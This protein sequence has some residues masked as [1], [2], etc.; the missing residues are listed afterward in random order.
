M[1]AERRKRECIGPPLGSAPWRHR[2]TSLGSTPRASE[3]AFHV[4]PLPS[5]NS[6]KAHREVLRQQARFPTA[7]AFGPVRTRR[8]RWVDRGKDQLSSYTALQ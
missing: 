5:F 4:S 2:K 8:P 3:K 1:Q 7:L 6:C